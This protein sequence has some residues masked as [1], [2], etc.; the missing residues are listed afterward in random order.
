MTGELHPAFFAA[1]IPAA[2]LIGVSKSGFGGSVSLLSVPLLALV[3]SPAKAAAI[4]LPM[5]ILADLI[6][7]WVF[8]N[9]VDWRNIK[10]M[11]PG[12]VLGVALGALTFR[13]T[14]D[15]LLR[16]MLGI[17]CLA[18][19]L[20]QTVLSKH[21]PQ[22]KQPDPVK[23]GIL[24]TF[25]GFTSFIANAG[26]PPFLI[27]MAPQKLDRILF[28]G[29]A[30]VF[31]ACIN[32]IKLGPFI[33]LGLFNATNLNATLIL[34]PAGLVGYFLGLKV[35]VRI[36]GKTFYRVIHAALFVTGLKLLWEVL[37]AIG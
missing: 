34:L 3:I 1:A 35:L 23:G 6:G 20:Q 16:G 26:G 25:S 15:T 12:A 2:V 17:M 7:L 21:Q 13:I 8:R 5:L 36:D 37:G 10:I 4:M 29:T 9:S 11:L 24:G 19:V 33:W 32:F 18:F 30:T 22:P 27:Y 31:F 14:S 28:A